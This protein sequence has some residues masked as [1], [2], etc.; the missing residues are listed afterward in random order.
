MPNLPAHID[1]AH[2]AAQLLDHPTLDSNKGYFLLGATSPDI[3][4]ITRRRREEYHFAH[5]DF[6]TIGA[7]VE[8]LFRS[9][10]RLGS[11][12][13]H[14][15]PTQAFIAGYVTHLIADEC[16]I[17]EIY[18]P[19]FG[20]PEVFA[21]DASAKVLDRALQLELD[22]Q[23]WGTVPDTLEAIEGATE[24]VDVDFI[25]SETL[26]D[27]RRWVVGSLSGNFTWDRLRFMARRIAAGDE[28]HPAHRVADEF[29]LGMPDTLKSLYESVPRSD[30]MRFREQTIVALAHS[31]ED[32]LP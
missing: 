30:L 17:A 4:V 11:A 16:W 15:G 27:W 10:P 22:W 2:Q 7:G 25:S 31:V 9:H 8:G 23:G 32:Y 6:E 24:S 1:L 12:S 26:A 19:Y 13:D 3:R 5:L 28:T 29:V 14:S 21:D 20:N 18:R